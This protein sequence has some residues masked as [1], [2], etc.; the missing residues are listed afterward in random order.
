MD[1][2]SICAWTA[3]ATWSAL[4]FGSWNTPSVADGSPFSFDVAVYCCAPS[5]TRATSPTRT[6][7]V[8][9]FAPLVLMMM[10]LNCCTVFRRPCATMVSC[11]S[12]LLLIGAAPICPAAAWMFW[13][14]IAL[15]TSC[16]VTPSAVICSGFI[17]TRIA[18]FMSEKFFTVP[19]PWIRCSG[20]W[21]LMS[22]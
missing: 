17:H 4:A 2:W 18:Y 9:P 22:A 21:T 16:E 11:C 10:S 8:P 20:Y 3:C 15:I 7:P 12:C 19:T 1:S 13:P 5:S 6:T 14:E